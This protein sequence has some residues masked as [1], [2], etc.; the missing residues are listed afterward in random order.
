MAGDGVREEGGTYGKLFGP[1]DMKQKKGIEAITH[2]VS[3]WR[4][5]IGTRFTR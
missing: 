5:H 1:H 4:I 2:D 3:V